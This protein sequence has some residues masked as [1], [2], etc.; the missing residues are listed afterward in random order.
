MQQRNFF[1]VANV[2]I[3]AVGPSGVRR[4]ETMILVS[5]T[6]LI[7]LQFLTALAAVALDYF[8]DVTQSHAVEAFGLGLP[9][10]F[11]QDGDRP[12]EIPQV[13]L[14]THDHGLRYS[15]SIHD[16]SFL[17]LPNPSEDLS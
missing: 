14:D 11:F 9:P 5:R 13:F 4:A 2:R 17:V 6:A 10:D 8:V 1:D 15:A 3:S 16:E 12:G 7:I